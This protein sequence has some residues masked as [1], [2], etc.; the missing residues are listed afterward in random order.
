MAILCP[1]PQSGAGRSTSGTHVHGQWAGL[2]YIKYSTF[3]LCK[4][5]IEVV[6]LGFSRFCLY[7]HGLE[8]PHGPIKTAGVRSREKKE[9]ETVR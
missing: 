3:K 2:L 5:H 1:S 6:A 7:M 4:T 8:L 9:E